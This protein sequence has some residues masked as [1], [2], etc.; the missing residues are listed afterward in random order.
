MQF[1]LDIV[2]SLGVIS[3]VVIQVER[4]SFGNLHT[5]LAVLVQSYAQRGDQTGSLARNIFLGDGKTG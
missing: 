4:L 1:I 3:F 5:T 2:F